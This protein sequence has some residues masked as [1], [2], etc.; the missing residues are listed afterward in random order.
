MTREELDTWI[1]E[2]GTGER[3]HYYCNKMSWLL[4]PMTDGWVAVFEIINGCSYIP[5]TQAVDMNKAK[6]FC[7]LTEPITVPINPI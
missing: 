7:N 2:N 5:S 3:E 6:T 1:E 4:V